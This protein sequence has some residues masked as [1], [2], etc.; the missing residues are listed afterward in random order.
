MHV[1]IAIFILPLL[2][3]ITSILGYVWLKQ[4]TIIPLL[5]FS[6]F[7]ILTSTLFNDNFFVWAII[8]T[9][10]SL[11]TSLITCQLRTLSA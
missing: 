11:L 2:I 8:Y 10:L 6:L 9:V 1:L 4:W 5:T 7:T 3:V